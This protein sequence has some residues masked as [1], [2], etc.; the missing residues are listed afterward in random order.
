MARLETIPYGGWMNCLRM[1]GDGVELVV[2]LDV[3]PRVIRFGAPG[4]QNL[5]KE[6]DDQMGK[7]SGTE[8]ASFGGHRLWHAPEVFPRTYALDFEPVGHTWKDDVLTLVQKTEPE[9]GIQ[10]EIEISIRNGTVYLTHRLINRNPWAIEVAPWALSVM[11]A[12]GRLLVPQE[13]FIP[14]PDVLTPARPLVLWHFTRMDDPRFVW[15]DRLIQ[16]REDPEVHCK[17]KFGVYNTKG[18]AAYQLG[19][20]LFLKG[21]PLIPGGAYP[22][23]GCNCEFF[24][25]PGFLEVE[26]VGPMAKLDPDGA[27]EHLEKWRM[28]PDVEL[29]TEEKPLIAALNPY[30]EDF[31]LP[32]IGM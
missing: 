3:G 30:L 7:T 1:A 16:M 12:G 15:G 14:H 10:K 29:P 21:I 31:G 5:F 6:F 24:T 26:S 9:T 28:I 22:D 18:W 25:M 4:R 11:A 8:W 32:P 17:Q 19:Q 13:D 27:T 23:M 20:D 2:T